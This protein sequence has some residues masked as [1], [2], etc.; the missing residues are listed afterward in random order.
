MERHSLE[1]LELMR[2]KESYSVG[3]GLLMLE[4]F[5]SCSVESRFCAMVL[6]T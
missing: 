1:N 6:T 5:D 3:R 4:T 2:F